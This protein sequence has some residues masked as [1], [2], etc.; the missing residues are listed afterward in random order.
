MTE[1]FSVP[2]NGAAAQRLWAD[3]SPPAGCW[4]VAHPTHAGVPHSSPIL[5]WVG[6]FA[7]TMTPI[8]DADDRDGVY[9]HPCPGV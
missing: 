6:L 5:A 7:E 1:L 3:T 4:P 9:L 8:T 2:E